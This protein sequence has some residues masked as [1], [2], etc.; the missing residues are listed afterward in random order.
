MMDLLGFMSLFPHF[1]APSWD[2]WRGILARL[3]SAI[4]ELFIIAG[5][6]SGKSMIAALLA[7]A[8]ASR[9]YPR[10]PGEFIYVGVFGPD[11]RQAGITFRYILGLLRSVPEL[12]QL[13]VN[14]TKESVELAGGVVLEVVTAS[15]AAPRGRAYA[16]AIIEEAA[17]L[18]TEDAADPDTELLRAVRPALA[19]VP[20]SLLVVIGTPYAMRGELYRAWRDWFNLPAAEKPADRLVVAADTL[21]LNPTFS[22]EEI[23]RAWR[24][25]PVAARSEYGRDGVI[26]F[27]T[28]VSGLLTDT[29]LDPVVPE[30]IRELAP[31][32]TRRAEGAFDAADG[33]EG[34]NAAAAAV[35]F[36]GQ[37]AELAAVRRW[38][39]PFNP[40]AVAAE[41]A[42]LFARF[43]LRKIWIDRRAPG[44]VADLFREHT[45]DCEVSALTTSETF[46]ELLPLINSQRV[47]LLDAP[48]LLQELRRLER[49][50]GNEG[51]EV[52]EHLPR[53]S[54]DVAAAAASALV[55]A[56]MT[57]A[58][59]SRSPVW[60]SERDTREI[61]SDLMT[62]PDAS[63]TVIR[64]QRL[65]LARY[66]EEQGVVL[67][68]W[69]P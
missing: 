8:F 3:T 12:D 9:E 43:G 27:R 18:P 55:H 14:E 53:G 6:G 51:R 20:G 17:F 38:K 31:D 69:K 58:K 44:M 11:R 10:A 21:T 19:R 57:A 13:I 47:T 64:M 41:A 34:G 36:V 48:E 25:D 46:R 49:R 37:P 52:I 16:L 61:I 22:R 65:A 35:A 4:R 40:S 56:A 1:R 63:P 66:C 62:R 50:P 39:A 42:A 30:S 2:G 15:T 29:M 33:V 67:E 23:E 54:D 5:R 45:I 26:G 28:D 32:P 68:R 24:D 60:G 59:P 7:C